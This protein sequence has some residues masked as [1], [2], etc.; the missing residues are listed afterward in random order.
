MNTTSFSNRL[1]PIAQSAIRESVEPSSVKEL[2]LHILSDPSFSTL[3][4]CGL[5]SVTQS[6]I[7]KGLTCILPSYVTQAFG[8]NQIKINGGGPK[9]T[10]SQTILFDSRDIVKWRNPDDIEPDEIEGT[11]IYNQQLYHIKQSA[12]RTGVIGQALIKK[13]NDITEIYQNERVFQELTYSQF[14]DPERQLLFIG[15]N[16]C[17]FK[18]FYELNEFEKSADIV[19]HRLLAFAIPGVHD[20]D[21]G[22][23]KQNKVFY[24]I[25]KALISA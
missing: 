17:H 23:N 21:I 16:D 13:M 19:R 7:A 24:W 10:D 20:G 18:P 14:N 12:L 3:A 25:L 8:Q 6:S 11:F 2:I 1:I 9:E 4:L 15:S 5:L 22:I